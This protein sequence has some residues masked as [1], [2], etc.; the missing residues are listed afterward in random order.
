MISWQTNKA[1]AANEVGAGVHADREDRARVAFLDA[2]SPPS[3][4]C[5]RDFTPP[6]TRAA[7][8]ARGG[9]GAKPH[10][11]AGRLRAGLPGRGRGWRGVADRSVSH[12]TAGADA[13]PPSTGGG[14][15]GRPRR[16]DRQRGAAGRAGRGW[17][18][19]GLHR[20][21]HR[22]AALADVVNQ[23]RPPRSFALAATAYWLNREL[24]LHVYRTLVLV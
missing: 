12:T 1:G 5:G 16:C 13:L 3:C 14:V 21:V 15:K 19:V 4:P 2:V 6:G 20:V 10:A 22:A 9:R 8:V 17:V 11:D 18:W 23:P 7:L 24:N